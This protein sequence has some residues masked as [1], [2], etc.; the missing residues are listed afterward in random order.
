MAWNKLIL[1]KYK[2]MKIGQKF[3]AELVTVNHLL[4]DE[5]E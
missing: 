5:P 4:L 2:A 3:I 1:K